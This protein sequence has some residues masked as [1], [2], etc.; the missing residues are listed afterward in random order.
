MWRIDFFALA[1]AFTPRTR[2]FL[3]NTPH[4]PTGKVFS[5]KELGLSATLCRKWDVIAVV[6]ETDEISNH[7]QFGSLEM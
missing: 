7:R 2:V 1:S 3:L 4:D 5:E 6:D